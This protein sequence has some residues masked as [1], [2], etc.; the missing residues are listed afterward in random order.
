MRIEEIT[1]E[2]FRSFY[3]KQTIKF[4]D[5]LTLFIG[6][7][8]DGK[9]TFF[10]AFEWL[11]NT[12]TKRVDDSIVSAKRASELMNNENDFV[13]VALRFEHDGINEIEKSFKFYKDNN[14]I[15]QTDNFNF[16]GYEDN[17]TERNKVD[18]GILLDRCFDASIRKYSL[19]RGENNLDI[20]KHREALKYLVDTFSEIKDFDP[21]YSDNEN[22]QG[23]IDYAVEKS[24]SAYQKAMRSDEKNSRQER[25]LR[26]DIDK[27]KKDISNIKDQL[28]SNKENFHIYKTKLEEL[29]NC[30]DI[31]EQLNKYNADLK[32]LKT[33]KDNEESRVNEDYSIKLLDDNW[34]LC[35]FAPILEEFQN[36][37]NVLS[38]EKRKLEKEENEKIGREKAL[39]EVN[40]S[41]KK[42][43]IPLAIHVPDE[44]TMKEMI[45]DEVC[46]VCG[47]EATKGSPAYEFM[48]NKLNEYI[49]SLQP[50]TEEKQE[51]LFINDYINEFEQF[52]SRFGFEKKDII[53]L[54]SIIKDDIDFNEKRKIKIK[55]IEDDIAKIEECKSKLLT[56]SNS[57]KE[58]ELQNAYINIINWNRN[59]DDSKRQ[60]ETL[61]KEEISIQSIIDK[62]QNDYDN[63]AKDTSAKIYSQIHIAFQ[64]IQE[65][66]K[67]AKKR[68][69]DDFLKL[70]QEK[71]NAYLEKLNIDGFYGIIRIRKTFDNSAEIDLIDSN[72]IIVKNENEALKTTKFMSVLFAISELTTLKRDNNYPLIFDAPTSSFAPQKEKDFF[73]IISNVNK[74]CIIFTKSFLN[75]EGNLD[76]DKVYS[77]NSSVYRLEKKRPFNNLDLTTIQSTINPIKQLSHD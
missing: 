69:T 24:N 75:E 28:K 61:E 4:S 46:K 17:G 19:F 35:G 6:D 25:I 8:G 67:Y 21:Y 62:L 32:T 56:Q 43:I 76:F 27:Y 31:S 34:I 3:G 65:A 77:L 52:S 20:F 48:V 59:K 47:R 42:G 57:I 29:E 12:S 33:K 9:T 38:L 10:D 55:E 44:S 49:I 71:S 1:I 2:N 18:G 63:L 53:K 58:E 51:P 15:I 37:V 66:F 74:Q 30:K 70:L 73:N 60:I 64:K 16:I 22:K 39:S 14:G 5:G 13:R 11:F 54:L 26:F 7:N 72:E 50:Q 23:F 40:N 68:N 41:L 45:N 36:K